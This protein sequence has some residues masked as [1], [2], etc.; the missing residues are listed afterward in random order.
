MKEV[1]LQECQ[2]NI[3]IMADKTFKRN[4][5]TLISTKTPLF[6]ITTNEEK[7]LTTFLDYFSRA[8]GYDCY[9]WDC[10]QSLRELKNGNLA[11]GKGSTKSALAI[12]DFI[13]DE[14]K[15]YA[16]NEDA[17][18]NLRKSGRKGIV[19][20]LLDFF[21]FISDTDPNIE[22]RLKTLASMD[23]VVSAIITGPFYKSTA[24]LEN[25]MPCIDFP[26]PN[27]E[28]VSAAL[29]VVV[30]GVSGKMTGIEQQT[31]DME[32]Q[33]INS[34]RG[35]TLIEA[36]AA[37]SKSL[38]VHKGWNLTTIY[39]EKKQI[40]KKSGILEFYD[41]SVSLQDVGGLQNLVNWIVDRKVCFSEEAEHYGLEKP[42][43]LLLLGVPG[44]GK[45]LVCKAI[46]G[47]WKMPL[48]RL[49]FGRLF[50]SLVGESEQQ[51]RSV[52]K[53]VETISPAILWI[54]EIEKG[55]SGSQSSGKTDGGTTSRV[56]STFLTWM[57]EKTAP[58]FV[59][60]TANDHSAIP[61]EF[62]RAGRF[63]ELFFIDLPTLKER[64]AIFDVHLRKRNWNVKDFDLN[65]LAQ[66]TENFMGSE[67][68]K[69]V[70]DA[71]L[72]G[73][74]DNKRPISTK[75]MTDCIG[76][77]KTLYSQRNV[78]IEKLQEYGNA[79]CVKANTDELSQ[80]TIVANI[81]TNPY[82]KNGTTKDL[83]IELINDITE[84]NNL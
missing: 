8:K 74:R 69:V 70:K 24:V 42:R 34:V 53:L 13:I 82:D 55:L 80:N 83:D 11:T 71:M 26:Y 19:Y 32:E 41:N 81:T 30:K 62:T 6:Y 31:K 64:M 59:V 40:I 50:G 28:E 75:D 43:G 49:D 48:L 72:I 79:N 51:T 16:G 52:L 9:V 73:F 3:E 77:I 45:S 67:I 33:L 23:T 14:A 47:T 54:D 35:L 66:K 57:Q 7:R 76:K 44:G 18:K 61:A 1:S 46:G 58:V 65:L 15:G 5:A 21:R 29:G 27:K 68:E 20:V 56:L 78:Q 10:F 22:R 36:Q 60:A 38:V 17:I 25:V 39:E 2:K 4:L 12:L 84:N 63:D 37:Y